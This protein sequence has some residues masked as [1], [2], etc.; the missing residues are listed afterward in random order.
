MHIYFHRDIFQ[1]LGKLNCR[2]REVEDDV[3]ERDSIE[4]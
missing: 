2:K 4:F 1:R 3:D